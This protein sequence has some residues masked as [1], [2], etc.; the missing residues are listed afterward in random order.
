MICNEKETKHQLFKTSEGSW[1]AAQKASD[2]RGPFSPA[3]K[4]TAGPEEVKWDKIQLKGLAEGMGRAV[5]SAASQLQHLWHQIFMMQMDAESSPR[6]AS[7]QHP[8]CEGASLTRL[9]EA[10]GLKYLGVARTIPSYP[11]CGD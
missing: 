11:P 3:D 10:H 7:A 8:I 9:R 1:I 6:P 2:T 4:N 5:A